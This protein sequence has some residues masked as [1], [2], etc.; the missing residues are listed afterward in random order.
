M[1][2]NGDNLLV[3]MDSDQKTDSGII[4]A[5]GLA[6]TG[7][8]YCDCDY[9]E[10]KAGTKVMIKPTAGVNI[11]FKGQL[12]R[13]CTSKELIAILDDSDLTTKSDNEDDL[14]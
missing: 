8:I 11:T 9:K 13:Q 7:S 1:K 4:L 14:K 6:T 3:V 12:L 5:G 2:C 10:L